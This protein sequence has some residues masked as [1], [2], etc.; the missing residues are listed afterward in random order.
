MK[1][2]KLIN[3]Y[4]AGDKLVEKYKYGIPTAEETDNRLYQSS[5]GTMLP[6]VKVNAE[7]PSW[8]R[9]LT[10][11]DLARLRS[12]Q[13]SSET[14]KSIAEKRATGTSGFMKDVNKLSWI[15]N[16]AMILAGG[17]SGALANPYLWGA[18]GLGSAAQNIEDKNYGEAALDVGLTFLGP[19]LQLLNKGVEAT[20]FGK[21]AR[22]ASELNK[23]VKSTRLQPKVVE[24]PVH[25]RFR[26]GDV[27]VNDP[28]LMYHVDNGDFTGF[29][30][31]GAY[32]KDN[33]LFP[34]KTKQS[35][36][37]YSWWNLGS[38]YRT[39]QSRLLVTTKDNPNFIK[40]RD[41][42]YPIGQWNGNK[43][44]VTNSEYVSSNPI[45]IGN[46]YVWEPG[47][48]YRKYSTNSNTLPLKIVEKPLK[49]LIKPVVKD[50]S[51]WTPEQ[52]TAAQDAA[53]A[54]GDMVEAQRLRD[55][56]S[57]LTPT[58]TPGKYY[59]GTKTK[60]TSYPDRHVDEEV[61]EMN[62]IYLTRKPKY[63]RTYGDVEEFYLRSNNPLETEG[64]W[65]GV[66]DDAARAE[67]EN[68][69][70]DAVVN[71]KFDTGF[72]NRLLRNSRDETITFNGK[73]IK[74]ADAV[75]YDNN[76]VRIPLGERD[77]FNI[78]DIRYY[79]SPN[80]EA[81][82]GVKY[83]EQ[84]PSSTSLD[85]EQQLAQRLKSY[86]PKV[87][88]NG[89]VEYKPLNS[90][91]VINIPEKAVEK[92]IQKYID[93]GIAREDAIERLREQF[94][95][96]AMTSN[97]KTFLLPEKYMITNPEYM[98]AH[99]AVH[100]VLRF[101]NSFN[102]PG[103]EG[104]NPNEAAAMISGEI[105]PALGIQANELLTEKML[106]KWLKATNDK[107]TGRYG[108]SSKIKNKKKFL[109]WA[110][111]VA[112]V[113]LLGGYGAYKVTNNNSYKEGVKLEN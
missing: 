67:I 22:I 101:D 28:N 34:G 2:K 72:L 51:K 76:G 109:E 19:E 66:I 24:N 60:R 46:Q 35:Q 9:N 78:N 79:E 1:M 14:A 49:K 12:G 110:N 90:S 36:E 84:T 93:S 59:R 91:D 53:I 105:K 4:Q 41:Q 29:S 42:N 16:G 95:Y 103:A 85:A 18:I 83:I 20:R 64:S 10:N 54:R 80:K 45:K 44:F 77:N 107:I 31:N 62:G 102:I 75:T 113:W 86:I 7:R 69:G 15:P 74:S 27:E 97:G 87:G 111:K 71:N 96:G 6:E 33:M 61:G 5:F 52:W 58:A 94:G 88:E 73:N 55:L 68:A 8:Q 23:A 50:I 100:R 92:Q 11:Y 98:K 48:G 13:I 3:K 112:P 21:S 82:K 65:T 17:L 25:T 89:L 56:H 81:M 70:Y 104:L 32:V 26:L 40:V 99:D 106:D 57:T 108:F 39:G 63:A 38:P 43:G 47:Y 37:S 30:G